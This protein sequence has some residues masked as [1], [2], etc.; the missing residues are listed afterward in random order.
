[1]VADVSKRF[2]QVLGALY[3]ILSVEFLYGHQLLETS[4]SA[5]AGLQ[6]Q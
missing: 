5:W 2:Y 6:V 4:S 3:L 1:M